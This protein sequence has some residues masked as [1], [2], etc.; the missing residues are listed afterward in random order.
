MRPRPAVGGRPLVFSST[1]SKIVCTIGPASRSEDVLA[2]MIDAGMDLVRLNLSHESHDSARVVFD[3][4]RSI[5]E[6][7]PILFDLQGPKIR[8]G[9]MKE[10][11]NLVAGEEFTLSIDTFVGDKTRVSIDHKELPQ[12]V[13]KGDIIAL[14]DGIIRLRVKRIDGNDVVTEVIHGGP[15]S[16][17]KGAN[18]PGIKLSC[19]V[20]TEEDIRDLDLAAD[21]EA[22][23]VALSFV[24]DA[25]DVK[26]LRRAMDERGLERAGIISKIEHTLAIKNFDTIL[27][28]SDGVMVARG[29]LGIEVPIEDVPIL[30]RNLIRRANIW[31]KP[32]IVATHMLESMT[33]EVVPTRAEVSDVAHAI[34][35]RA[36]AVMLSAETAVG[37]DPVAAVTMMERI[38]KRAEGVLPRQDP[39]E[40]TSPKRMIVEIIG[41][42][43]Y[44]AVDLIPDKVE[45]IITSTRTGY[46]ARWISKFRPPVPIYA[47]T[48]DVKVARKLRLLWGVHPLR[49]EQ[50]LDN[51]DSLV[52]ASAQVAYER[53]LIHRDKDIVFTSGVQMIPGRTNVVGVFHVKDLV[54]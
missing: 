12:D 40:V 31:A 3:R 41:N 30:Q 15:I 27:E 44:S 26:R 6:N 17:R 34:L 38:I 8:I 19:K 9:E 36:D 16:S 51:V 54:N 5:D 35:E 7:I 14:N 39:E 2:R 49:Q 45:A 33:E 50:H 47:V 11:V 53:G 43:T 28:E 42:L 37:V 10:P 1:N 21:L 29:D 25:D 46:T 22:D 13:K 32:V 20:P 4:I 52:Q 48:G 18:I 24:T 23:Y